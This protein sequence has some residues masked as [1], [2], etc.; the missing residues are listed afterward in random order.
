[1][2]RPN[3][4]LSASFWSV[5]V[6]AESTGQWKSLEGAGEIVQDLRLLAPKPNNLRFFLGPT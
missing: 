4:F 1:M 5:E 3:S 2:G 6:T